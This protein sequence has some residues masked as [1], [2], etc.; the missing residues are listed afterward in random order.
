MAMKIFLRILAVIYAFAAGKHLA[1]IMGFGELPWAA[2]PLVWQI[3]DLSYLA[4]DS[5]AAVGLFTQKRWGIAAFL[6]AAIS[7]ILLFTFAPHWFV[8]RPEHLL[9]LRGFII[10]HVC[11]IGI[12]FWLW[13]RDTHLD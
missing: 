13:R 9:L 10:Y 12:W 11:A 5:I 2:A 1:N 7:E 3:A 8:L 4:L 6:L